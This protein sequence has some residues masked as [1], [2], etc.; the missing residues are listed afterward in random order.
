[1][2]FCITLRNLLVQIIQRVAVVEST[3]YK[4]YSHVMNIYRAL[5]EMTLVIYNLVILC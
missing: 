3:I 2:I 5:V 4:Q 1:M